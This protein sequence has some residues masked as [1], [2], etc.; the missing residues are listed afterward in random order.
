MAGRVETAVAAGYHV[1][2]SEPSASETD[3]PF[4]GLSDLLADLLPAISA[5]IPGPQLEALEV[6]LLLR[7]AGEDPP[8]AHAIGLGVL[9]ACAAA[10]PKAR[11]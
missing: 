9:A 8:T 10:C 7:P 11:C 2:R 5:Q 6:A 3:L 1:L 4:A